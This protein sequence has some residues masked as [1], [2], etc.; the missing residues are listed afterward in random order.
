MHSPKNKIT[1][2]LLAGGMSHRMGKEKGFIRI[3]PKYLYQYAL[4]VLDN[5]C[6]EVLI[7]T[8][9]E[10][11]FLEKYPLVCD[12]IPGIGP[13][14]GINTCLKQSS[15]EINVVLS[16]DMPLEMKN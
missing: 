9:K 5:L 1:G 7:S 10:G 2:I 13:M 14:G 11:L 12:E 3:G 8:C 4:Q 16:Y 6:D 15:N